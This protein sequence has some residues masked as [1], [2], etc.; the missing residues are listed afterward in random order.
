MNHEET[1]EYNPELETMGDILDGDPRA[2]FLKTYTRRQAIRLAA[3]AAASV[4]VFGPGDPRTEPLAYPIDIDFL[5]DERLKA[6]GELTAVSFNNNFSNPEKLLRDAWL[7]TAQAALQRTIR[8]EVPRDEYMRMV[9]QAKA[10]GDHSPVIF[11]VG[12]TDERVSP[13]NMSTLT[14]DPLKGMEVRVT[15]DGVHNGLMLGMQRDSVRT[16]YAPDDK[17]GQSRIIETT[18]KQFG[19]AKDGDGQ[20]VMLF[21]W[22]PSKLSGE[23]RSAQLT[24]RF[25]EALSLLAHRNPGIHNMYRLPGTSEEENAFFRQTSGPYES[26]FGFGPQGDRIGLLTAPEFST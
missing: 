14:V 19:F 17:H 26:L 8:K 6:N 22:D 25:T 10:T 3:T 24:E 20:L 2:Q 16:A 13:Y 11:L 4:V 15:D 9:Q 12:G 1:R 21:N 5:V 23:T 7:S 18:S